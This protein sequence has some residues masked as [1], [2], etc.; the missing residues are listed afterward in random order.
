VLD[1]NI[2]IREELEVLIVKVVLKPSL[3][4]AKKLAT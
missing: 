1:N 3:I 4:L 2:P